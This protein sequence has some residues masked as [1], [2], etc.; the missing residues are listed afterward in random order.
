MK[1]F[2]NILLSLSFLLL[3]SGCSKP[4]ANSRIIKI[5]LLS[6]A[7][8]E[9]AV[10]GKASESGAILYINEYN[11]NQDNIH[12][13]YIKNDD[14]SDAAKSL[15]CLDNL[16]DKDVV[17]IVANTVTTPSLAIAPK[18][19]KLGLPLI[20]SIGTGNEITHNSTKNSVYK[21]V[22]RTALIDEFQGKKMAEFCVNELKIK[23]ASILYCAENDYSIN[24]KD[25][26]SNKL[27]ELNANV[28]T[29]EAFANNWD[30]S[31]YATKI[32]QNK[33][34]VLFIPHYYNTINLIAPAMRNAG[35]ECPIIGADGWDSILENISDKNSIEG[36]YYCSGYSSERECE[37]S[38]KFLVSY[39]KT[40]K[41][42]G[43]MFAAQGYDSAKILI[44]SI[45]K[46]IENGSNISNIKEFRQEIITQLPNTDL[47]CVTGHINFDTLHN[48]LKKLF[49]LKIING[50]SELYKEI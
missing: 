6:S 20:I 28:K 44:T 50:K 31:A 42:E 19:E 13:E 16:Y 37:L 22:F 36:S 32:A 15:V 8:G 46:A 45:E 34:D 1:S 27:K 7:T 38:Q 14:Q 40:Y 49:I 39:K 47:D 25:A 24:V 35:L 3:T 2:L 17:G 5:G 12:I 11:K 26:F 9:G 41:N 33:P 30:F 29:E 48:P 18:S 43:N 10:Y 23:N 4:A 21:N